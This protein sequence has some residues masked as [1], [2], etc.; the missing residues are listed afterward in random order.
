MYAMKSNV[1]IL[2]I[3]LLFASI[4]T[5]GCGRKGMPADLKRAFDKYTG[6]WNTGQFDEIEEVMAEDFELVESPDYVPQGGIDSFKKL[7]ANNRTTFPDFKLVIN[8]TVYEEGKIAYIWTVTGTNKVPGEIEPSG[9]TINGKGISVIHFKDSK[10][11]DE[12]RG[13]N[14]LLWLMQMGYTIGQPAPAEK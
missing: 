6:Y 1:R 5:P 10:I 13:N 14:N 12:W 2:I 8:E 11:K 3:M 7:I 9:R 4:L